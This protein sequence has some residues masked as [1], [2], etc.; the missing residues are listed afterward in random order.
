VPGATR[1]NLSSYIEGEATM[2]SREE[3]AEL[4]HK[5]YVIG[6]RSKFAE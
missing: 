2:A 5:K 6:D 4:S 1:L 3:M